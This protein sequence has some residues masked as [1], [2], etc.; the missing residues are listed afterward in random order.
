[1]NVARKINTFMWTFCNWVTV[2]LYILTLCFTWY[3]RF[4]IHIYDI[5]IQLLKKYSLT[6][7]DKCLNFIWKIPS[8]QN[9]TL[10][11]TMHVK[12]NRQNTL[13]EAPVLHDWTSNK[14]VKTCWRWNKKRRSRCT[15]IT[16]N[17]PLSTYIQNVNCSCIVRNY[18]CR[19]VHKDLFKFSMCIQHGDHNGRHVGCTH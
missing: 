3:S 16:L 7:P 1:M 2:F 17:H 5:I 8:T 14:K 15:K 9:K 10:K 6:I 12:L 11:I 13:N 4:S 19:K 18:T